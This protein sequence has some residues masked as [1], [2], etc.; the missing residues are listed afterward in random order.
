VHRRAAVRLLGL[1]LGRI[2]GV[3]GFGYAVT[4]DEPLRALRRAAPPMF[5]L[6]RVG[7]LWSRLRQTL[8]WR[9]ALWSA[10]AMAVAFA[11]A[12]IDAWVPAHWLPT[13]PAG[14]VDD[15]LRIMASSM[16]VVSTFSLS[17]LANAYASASSAG[18][19]RATRLVVAEPRSQK[20]VAVFLAAFIFSMVGLIALGTGRYGPAGR[21]ALFVC[22]LG[23]LAWVVVSFM[24]YIDVLSRIGRVSHTIETVERAAAK[25]LRRYARQPLAGARAAVGP[26]D[27][28]R[29]VLS[30]RTGHVQ[31]VDVAALQALAVRCDALV[32]VAASVGDLVHPK[33][34]LAWVRAAATGDDA[35]DR[36]QDDA[37]VREAFVV[38]PERTFEQ[39]PGYGLI[40][41][42]EIA[43]RALSP[44]VNDPGTAI[45]VLGSQTRLLIETLSV[46]RETGA[47]VCDRVTAAAASPQALV[48]IA[49]EPIAR[50]SA[51][52][53]EVMVQLLRH[54]DAL[55]GN[56]PPAVR[57]AVQEMVQRTLARAAR[58]GADAADLASWT[59]E[60]RALG[61]VPTAGIQDRAPAG[62][63]TLPVPRR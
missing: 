4:D 47:E 20:A 50:S 36:E 3:G 11:S 6:N 9:P 45:A 61:L 27:H 48:A 2:E 13:L 25:T 18:T 43:Q 33:A 53:F 60:A 32:H 28:A 37:R 51:G 56:A 59:H 55:V 17:V 34:P 22:A 12:L 35:G 7:L 57:T 41:L 16:L 21:L 42:A 30:T 49:Y 40:V 54:L 14:V 29:P 5:D 38:G 31:F 24:S 26:P 63:A 52:Q 8:W 46:P 44:A 19:P 23:V 10:A 62:A 15:L 39:D 1:A 58:A